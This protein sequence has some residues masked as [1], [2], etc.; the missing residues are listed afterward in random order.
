MTYGTMIGQAKRLLQESLTRPLVIP[1]AAEALAIC[2]ARTRLY[3]VVSGGLTLHLNLRSGGRRRFP[4]FPG[5]GPTGPELEILNVLHRHLRTAA[6]Q[7]PDAPPAAPGRGTA[8]R[9]VRAGDLAGA[10]FDLLAGH[11]DVWHGPPLPASQPLAGGGV[12]VT[13]C[14][15][16][17]LAQALT[18]LDR[19]LELPLYAAAATPGLDPPTRRL[20]LA[21]ANNSRTVT[22]RQL[23]EYAAHV[24]RL[25]RT[26]PR[27]TVETLDLADAVVPRLPTD[28]QPE[29]LANLVAELGEIAQRNPRTL[30]IPDLAAIASV[31]ARASALTAFVTAPVGGPTGPALA[32]AGRWRQLRHDLHSFAIPTP[33]HRLTTAANQFASWADPIINQGH[34][35][36]PVTASTWLP[37]AASITDELADLAYTVTRTIAR[38]ANAGDLLLPFDPSTRGREHLYQA[39]KPTDPRVIRLRRTAAATHQAASSLARDVASRPAVT[40][41]SARTGPPYPHPRAARLRDGTSPPPGG[42]HPLPAIGRQL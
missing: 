20:L 42:V 16:A 37:A 13:A 36:R 4:E 31:A 17:Q 38:A 32:S 29:Q 3:R 28:A 2:H 27:R 8:A 11:L 40:P 30:S 5:D 35:F 21:T 14:D 25:M 24:H 12:R 41:N 9:L 33:G 1:N 22:R 18:A 15:A 7:L 26:P 34:R 23:G 6:R 39:V 19:R 10:A